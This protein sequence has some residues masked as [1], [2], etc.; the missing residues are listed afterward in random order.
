LFVIHRQLEKLE[1][2]ESSDAME[3]ADDNGYP[4]ER[5]HESARRIGS[6]GVPAV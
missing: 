4:L 5:S 6:E 3:A 1:S 2:S